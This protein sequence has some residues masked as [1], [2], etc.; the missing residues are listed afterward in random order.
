MADS[1]SHAIV[2]FLKDK[3]HKISTIEVTNIKE[4]KRDRP[5]DRY[6]FISDHIYYGRVNATSPYQPISIFA[7]GCKY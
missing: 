6:D 5:N 1:V 7:L 4:L 3:G 2:R